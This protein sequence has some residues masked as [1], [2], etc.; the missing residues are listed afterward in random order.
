MTLHQV[1]NPLR[2][3][4]EIALKRKGEIERGREMSNNNMASYDEWMARAVELL[5]RVELERQL[6]RRP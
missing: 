2:T 1:G 3:E 5:L 4:I 6:G